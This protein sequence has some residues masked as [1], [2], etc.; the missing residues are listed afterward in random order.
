MHSFLRR[1][2]VQRKKF[3]VTT[4]KLQKGQFVQ[5]QVANFGPSTSSSSSSLVFSWPRRVGWIAATVNTARHARRD[6]TRRRSATKRE[7]TEATRESPSFEYLLFIFSQECAQQGYRRGAA[8]AIF[9]DLNLHE[10][11]RNR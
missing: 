5:N 9:G 1:V 10:I 6:D 7:P 8:E 2:R 4:L 3:N 11:A